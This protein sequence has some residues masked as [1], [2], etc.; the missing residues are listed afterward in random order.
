MNREILKQDEPLNGKLSSK[1]QKSSKSQ[2]PKPKAAI[3]RRGLVFGAWDFFG[4]WILGFGN[5]LNRE[6]S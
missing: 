6:K 4:V 1:H 2:A 5:P 3:S